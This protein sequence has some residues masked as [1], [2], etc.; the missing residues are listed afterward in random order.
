M[1]YSI[2]VVITDCWS[3]IEIQIFFVWDVRA[4]DMFSHENKASSN[5]RENGVNLCEK[6][7][8]EHSQLLVL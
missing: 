3:V 1:A 4:L 5:L 7:N 2:L 6:E 8:G